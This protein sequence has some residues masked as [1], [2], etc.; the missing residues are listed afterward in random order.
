MYLWSL[1]MALA[2]VKSFAPWSLIFFGPFMVV[3]WSGTGTRL[4][5]CERGLVQLDKLVA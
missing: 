3:E 2:T 5:D 1:V 4:N